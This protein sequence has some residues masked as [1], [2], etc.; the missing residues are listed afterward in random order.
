[1]IALGG[2]QTVVFGLVPLMFLDGDDLLR[3]SKT[4]WLGLWSVGLLW[5]AVVVVNPALSHQSGDNVSI[6]WLCG[7]L[8]FQAIVAFG[9][10]VLR[11]APARRTRRLRRELEHRAVV[12]ELEE[13][14]RGPTR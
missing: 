5:L 4:V 2:M 1:M 7:L 14:K 8:A 10:W 13:A 3:W 11:R 9:L 6:A 12:V